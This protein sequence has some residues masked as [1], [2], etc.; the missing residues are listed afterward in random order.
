MGPGIFGPALG[1]R[2]SEIHMSKVDILPVFLIE[3]TFHLLWPFKC[4]C[5]LKYAVKGTGNVLFI[6]LGFSYICREASA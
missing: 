5:F 2:V 6:A 1:S 3:Q 4:L